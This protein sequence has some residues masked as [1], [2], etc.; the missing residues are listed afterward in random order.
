MICFKLHT[1]NGTRFVPEISGGVQETCKNT[2]GDDVVSKLCGLAA[3]S[4]FTAPLKAVLKA[5]FP[6]PILLEVFSTNGILKWK[7]DNFKKAEIDARNRM[8]ALF[9]SPIFYLGSCERGYKMRLRL[10]VNGFQEGSNSHMSLSLI[11]LKGPSDDILPWPLKTKV[12]FM[13]MNPAQGETFS[14]LFT[15]DPFLK[16]TSLSEF[17]GAEAGYNQFIDLDFVPSYIKDDA[18]FIKCIVELLN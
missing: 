8:N 4:E 17:E 2:T 11:I 9:Y 1:Y 3:R 6:E 18:I 12:K 15:P 13:L 7:V 16:P 14:E 5:K 10:A